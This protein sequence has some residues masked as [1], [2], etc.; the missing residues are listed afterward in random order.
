MVWLIT[1]V[2]IGLLFVCLGMAF[3]VY[4]RARVEDLQAVI[5]A[6]QKCMDRMESERS[7][8]RSKVVKS[9][10][11]Q[12]PH[13]WQLGRAHAAP[14]TSRFLRRGTGYRIDPSAN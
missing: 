2:V 6:Q 8:G 4:H 13:G 11:G 14:Q 12:I 3:L 9:A 1:S 7:C 10:Q 5:R